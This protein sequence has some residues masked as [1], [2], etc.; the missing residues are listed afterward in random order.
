MRPTLRRSMVRAAALA[1]A[2]SLPLTFTASAGAATT[3]PDVPDVLANVVAG[4]VKGKNVKKHLD[5]FLKIA[6]ANGG[7]RAAGTPGYDASL[8]YVQGKLRKAGYRTSTTDVEFPVSWEELSPPVLEQKT[9]EAKTYA[10]PA[11][12]VTVAHSSG[13]DVTAQIQVVDAVIPVPSTPNTSTAGCEAS[14]FAGFVPGRI[15]LIQRG[16]CAFVDKATNAKA[17][18]AAGV[19]FFNEGQPGRTDP[20]VFDIV[21]WRFGFPIV[22]ASTAVGLDLA[23]S[24]GT[25]VRLKVD[26][27][28]TVGRTRN[29]IAESRWGRPGE[30]VMV[31]AHLDSVPEGAGINDNGSG[32][33]AI[34]ETALK[35]AHVPTKNRLRFAW[36]GAEELG[37]L[38]SEQYVAGLSQAE[39]D[40]IRLYLNFDMVAS[41]NDVTFLYDG[42]DS[43]GEGAPAGPAGSAE[44]EKRLE[45]FYTKRGLGFEGTDFTGRSDYGAFIANGIPAGGIFTGAEGIKTPEQAAR[46]GGTAG[47]AYDPCYHSACDGIDNINA[48]ALDRNSKAIGYATAFYA[49]DLSSIPD[50]DAATAAKT[51]AGTAAPVTPAHGEAAR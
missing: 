21:E 12:F 23:D 29:L 3:A 5:E 42:D 25:T 20:F 18:G 38:G 45:R 9:P 6:E 32:S 49:Y 51:A 19:I 31:G 10:T 14:D 7:N 28:T 4:Q 46:F 39:R 15:A 13:G 27:K 37:L 17:A 1:A 50:R 47:V 34:L 35:L 30:V 43:D 41:P 36:W 26:A 22:F 16:T 8:A 11:D 24:P 2:V 40:R 44:I 33:A 48:A